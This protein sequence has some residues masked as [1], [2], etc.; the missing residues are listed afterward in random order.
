MD[1]I[2]SKVTPILL[3]EL[4]DFVK[5]NNAWGTG[6]YEVNRVRNRRAVKYVDATFD[7]RTGCVYKIDLR[8]ITGHE[9][10]S[11]RV[12]TGAGL[13]DVIDFLNEPLEVE[14]ENDSMQ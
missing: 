7:S 3:A 8:G 14:Q 12:D 5:K 2:E 4:L 13:K 1:M 10:I 11:F 9:E 6:M